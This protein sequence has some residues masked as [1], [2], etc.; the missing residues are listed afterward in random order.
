MW[1]ELV[2][3]SSWADETL[4]TGVTATLGDD[5]RSGLA[6]PK[7]CQHTAPFTK[8]VSRI[9]LKW[10]EFTYYP[11]TLF[12]NQFSIKSCQTIRYKRFRR[13]IVCLFIVVYHPCHFLL[14]LLLQLHK[15]YCV[16][17]TFGFTPCRWRL[18]IPLITVHEVGV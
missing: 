17:I 3:N 13:Q 18:T 14:W 2:L 4:S 11:G 12:C 6:G 5:R 10:T 16:H 8:I 9:C 15:I 1:S 7:T